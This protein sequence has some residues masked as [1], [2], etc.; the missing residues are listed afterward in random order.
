MQIHNEEVSIEELLKKTNPREDIHKNCGKGIY[1]SN[2]QQEVLKNFGFSVE[3]YPNL[4]SLLFDIEEYLNENYDEDL[5][6]LES[7]A[8]ALSEFNYYQNT[9]K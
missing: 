5:E 3:K 8:S 7:V 2:A 6:D 4:K 9:N 1:L